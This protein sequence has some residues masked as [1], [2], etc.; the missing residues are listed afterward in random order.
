MERRILGDETLNVLLHSSTTYLCKA[1]YSAPIVRREYQAFKSPEKKLPKIQPSQNTT[2]F[3]IIFED[4]AKST[5][6][7]LYSF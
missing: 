6:T 5:L 2:T 7:F 3:C 1:G 4:C